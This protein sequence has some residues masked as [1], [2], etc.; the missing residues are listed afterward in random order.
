ME[1]ALKPILNHDKGNRTQREKAKMKNPVICFCC[2]FL[3]L[4]IPACHDGGGAAIDTGGDAGAD[5]DTDADT[6][7]DADSD[8]DTD[9]GTES[10]IIPDDR[11]V[12]WAGHVGI[13]GGIPIRTT[14]CETI[15]AQAFGDGIADATAAIQ[16][17]LDNCPEDEVVL[18]PAGIYRVT[19]KISIWSH[20][21]LRGEGMD[22][23]VI[24]YEGVAGGR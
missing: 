13:P 19:D 4:Q 15:D 9:S 6:D 17:A 1:S 12:E 16:T 21:V 11:R 20:K 23:T 24:S 3:C 2:F 8:S 7:G 10:D 14:V 22:K 18:L 5:A